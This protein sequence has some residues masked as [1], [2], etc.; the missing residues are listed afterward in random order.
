MTTAN[1]RKNCEVF[2]GRIRVPRAVPRRV[3]SGRIGLGRVKPSMANR[4]AAE[5]AAAIVVVGNLT[6]I[7]R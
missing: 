2:L 3:G 6:R 7:C 5:A 4:L 1:C